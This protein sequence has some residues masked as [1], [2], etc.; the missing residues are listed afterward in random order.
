[1][2]SRHKKSPKWAVSGSIKSG[3]GFVAV[4]MLG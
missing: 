2:D 4:L 3:A 1:M